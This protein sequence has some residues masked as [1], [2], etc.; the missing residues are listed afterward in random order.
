MAVDE[1]QP[2]IQGG[3]YRLLKCE[4]CSHSLWLQAPMTMTKC[5]ACGGKLA[6]KAVQAE[7]P[8]AAD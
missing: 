3:M 6:V 2:P 1:K 5:Q 4:K 7:A 8:D